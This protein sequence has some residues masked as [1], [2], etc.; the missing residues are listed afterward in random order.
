MATDGE[1]LRSLYLTFL[2]STQMRLLFLLLLLGIFTIMNL[3]CRYKWVPLTN[4]QTWVGPGLGDRNPK[5]DWGSVNEPEK[6]C[7]REGRAQEGGGYQVWHFALL[8]SSRVITKFFLFVL[9]PIRS[10]LN[11]PWLSQVQNRI[12]IVTF[13]GGKLLLL[14][15]LRVILE[16]W[17]LKQPSVLERDFDL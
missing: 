8:F 7:D 1:K 16:S 12:S 13:F 4:H 15:H 14:F 17:G 9:N 11:P 5:I 10:V 6:Q 2:A 3:N